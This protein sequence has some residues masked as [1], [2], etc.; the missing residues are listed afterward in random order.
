MKL[1][2]PPLRSVT[3]IARLLEAHADLHVL[4]LHVESLNLPDSWIG[5]GFSAV[6]F[7]MCFTTAAS[8]PRGLTM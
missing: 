4:L 7:G 5:A 3:D 2:A 8:M 1:P 6:P